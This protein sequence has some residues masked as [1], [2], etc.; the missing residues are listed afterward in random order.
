MAIFSV[1]TNQSTNESM[2]FTEEIRIR[3]IVLESSVS[4]F[5]LILIYLT[6]AFCVYEWKKPA[7]SF[8]ALLK[9]Q[10]NLRVNLK[11]GV[12]M[13]F[14]L[15]IALIFLMGRFICEHYELVKQ[16][17]M[18][19]YS[20]CD[21]TNKVKMVLTTINVAGVY[22]FLWTR[23]RFCYAQTAMNHLSTS[24]TR[25][26]SWVSLILLFLAQFLGTILF[27][28]TRDFITTPQ[29]CLAVQST[30]IPLE[31]AWIFVAVTTISF[32]ILLATLFIYPLLRH[33]M[34]VQNQTNFNK[35]FPLIKRTAIT[36]IIC[37]VTDLLSSLLILYGRDEYG[38][39]P[40]LVYDVSAL[41]N[42]IC[43]F[44]SFGD[45]KL[46]ILSPFHCCQGEEKWRSRESSTH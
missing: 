12:A 27:V 8:R 5:S 35:F 9:H 11:F 10:T 17:W 4:F 24:L 40:T 22:L 21:T 30:E 46:Q 42:V 15:L 3:F 32:Q 45:W 29:G 33:K 39:T 13:R 20:Y 26:A 19:T 36:T 44:A 25:A 18:V 37:V 38:I 6:I 43:I 34:L 7:G 1:T 2:E 41:T 16:Y 28:K 23:Q 31:V 14:E